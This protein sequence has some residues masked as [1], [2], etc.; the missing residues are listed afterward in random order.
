MAQDESESIA[1]VLA[2][3]VA[4]RLE[5]VGRTRDTIDTLPRDRATGKSSVPFL[6][7][8]TSD[9]P[10][11][12]L[13]RTDKA[14]RRDEG[15]EA[16]TACILNRC[17]SMS[18]CFMH[19]VHAAP[20]ITT[21]PSVMYVAISRLCSHSFAR[22]RR[23]LHP[24]PGACCGCIGGSVAQ[25]ESE[26]TGDVLAALAAAGL[27]SVGRKR[28]TIDSL[29]RDHATCNSSVPFLPVSCSDAPK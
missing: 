28:D 21:N 17:I 7:V 10:T 14:R 22:C 16:A 26:S 19:V 15:E 1:D 25:G 12:H 5:S 18:D 9:A 27:E 3:L 20:C 4:A 24:L 29:P 2:A 11:D 8:S 23:H 13:C 6:P